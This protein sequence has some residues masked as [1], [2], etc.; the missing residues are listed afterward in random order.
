MFEDTHPPHLPF[1]FLNI[2][3]RDGIPVTV[4]G[5]FFLFVGA[6]EIRFEDVPL[7]CG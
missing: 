1:F 7:I 5:R 6:L 2:P 3:L 4:T